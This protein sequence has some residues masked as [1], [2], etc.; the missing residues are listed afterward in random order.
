MRGIAVAVALVAAMC[1]ASAAIAA[2]PP[3]PDPI[4]NQAVY[5]YAGVFGADTIA[6]LEQ[7]IDVIEDRT[8]AEVVV[9]TQV[10]PGAD[11][12]STERDAIALIDAWGIGRAG[13]DDG[14][15][16]L[17]NLDESRLRGQVQLY[18]APGFRSSYLSNDERQAIFE[19]EMLPRLRAGDL[20]GAVLVAM[21]KVD[22]A[23]TEGHAARLRLARQIDAVL[24]LVAAP[25]AFVILVGF[26]VA[27]W[28]RFGRDPVYLD[29]PSIHIPAPPPD[30][31]AAS[32]ALVRDGWSNRRALTTALLDL[33][34]RGRLAFREEAAGLLGRGRKVG[35]EL[36]P[37][38]T[39]PVTEARRARN[40]RRPIGDAE[41]YAFEELR[42]LGK[43]G[44][45]EPGALPKFGSSV[46]AFD[47]RLEGHV[48]RKGWF[49]ARPSKVA[50]GWFIG[51]GTAIVLGIIGGA[52]GLALPSAGLLMLGVAVGAAGVVLMLVG[53]VMPAVTGP[54]AMIRAMLAAYRRTLEKTMAQARSMQQVVD[55]AQ[56]DWLETPDQAIVWGV[57]LGLHR[58]ID[59]VLRRTMEDIREGTAVGSAYLPA[60]YSAA[61]SGGG[62]AGGGSGGG[63]FSSSAIPNVGGMIGVLSTIGNAPGSSGSGG[64]FGGGGS[65]GGG[66]GAG[67]GF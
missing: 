33:A 22:E 18:A 39:D 40:R 15:V 38:A 66:G 44:Y 62:P 7:T 53:R 54:G 23:A 2:G 59:Q 10:K 16:I 31:T 12:G 49:A 37:P 4:P 50:M 42:S 30:L 5:D 14:M 41:E 13:F 9:Y 34:S 46:G 52:I 47:E 20:D 6:S 17:F 19:E 25:L 48:V 11:K 21:A 8:G 63:L 61:G 26:G 65:G 35:I 36:D 3:F 24:G 58:E 60:W 57:A 64:G 29:D 45:V 67:G 27:R 32:A 56:L 1:G 55:E 28:W 51:G 43:D